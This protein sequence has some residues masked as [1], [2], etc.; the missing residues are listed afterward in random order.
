MMY[1]SGSFRKVIWEKAFK[2]TTNKRNY[3]LILVSITGNARRKWKKMVGGWGGWWW[4]QQ[5]WILWSWT[6]SPE[7]G[8]LRGD[9]GT[10]PAKYWGKRIPGGRSVWRSPERVRS[11]A[12]LSQGRKTSAAG[13]SWVT[14]VLR[15]NLERG[16]AQTPG[17]CPQDWGVWDL[18]SAHH[19]SDCVTQLCSVPW[20][21]SSS[22]H[23]P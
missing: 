13:A 17:P 6:A 20:I 12:P 21:Q 3:N 4:W 19:K 22:W 5:L 16:G 8:R 7:R 23:G 18:L 9:L 11:L 15:E 14:A 2:K 1:P 10:S